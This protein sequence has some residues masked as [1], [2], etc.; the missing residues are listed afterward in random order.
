MIVQGSDTADQKLIKILIHQ[1]DMT[2]PVCRLYFGVLCWALRDA[3]VGNYMCRPETRQDAI[4]YVQGPMPHA[5]AIGLSPSYIRRKL[6]QFGFDVDAARKQAD[7]LVSDRNLAK[8]RKMLA[9]A[10]K[11]SKHQ[12]SIS[13]GV[14]NSG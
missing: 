2:V 10:E 14:R 5:Q 8:R 7:Q 3:V 13:V 11:T 9:I 1:V 12:P 6:A 4:E